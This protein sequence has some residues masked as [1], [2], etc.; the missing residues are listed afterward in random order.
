MSLERREPPRQRETSVAG[1]YL[2]QALDALRYSASAERLYR[3]VSD[4]HKGSLFE[5]AQHGFNARNAR[6]RYLRAS[7]LFS[8]LAAEALANEFLAA[9][10]R[11]R[12]V[13]ALD[14][15]RTPDKLLL[16]P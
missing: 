4:L 10:L 12:E 14:R 9:L 8:A 16:G 1:A 13:E 6:L 11:K 5:G 2:E 15:L 7:V 3:E